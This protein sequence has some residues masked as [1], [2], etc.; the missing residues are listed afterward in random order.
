M[1]ESDP[2]FLGYRSAEQDRLR[3]QA[4]ELAGEARWLLDQCRLATGARAIDVGCGP[5]GILDLLAERVGPKGSVVGLERGEEAVG[6]AR[7]FVAERQ[8]ANAEVVQ[9]DA[10]ATGFPRGS[11]DLAH[12]RLVLV[13]V[14]EPEQVIAELVALVRP[15]GMVASHEADYVAHLCDPPLPAWTRLLEVLETY[16]RLNGIDLFVGRRV[17]G[18][19]RAA[20]LVDVHV[21]PVIHVYPHGH[22]RRTILLNFVENL[23]DRLLA[24]GLVTETELSDLMA[25]L[26]RHLDDPGTLVVSHL[27]FQTWGRKPA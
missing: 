3:R 24:Q 26:Q 21:H 4:E 25:S 12:A 1:P 14:P 23:R 9:G 6:L 16:S 27:F 22:G 20:G 17:H 13:N 15:G 11:F 2:Y 10:K 7:A 18:M 19:L 5:Q 8:L